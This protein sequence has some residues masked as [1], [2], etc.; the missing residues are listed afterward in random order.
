MGEF[1]QDVR[2]ALRGLRKS[3]GFA[4]AMIVTLAPGLGAST[5]I[6]GALGASRAWTR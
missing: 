2:Y 5:A 1:A 3:P 4:V 6:L